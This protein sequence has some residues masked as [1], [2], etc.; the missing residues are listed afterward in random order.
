MDKQDITNITV[1]PVMAVVMIEMKTNHLL[2]VELTILDKNNEDDVNIS[3]SCR[4]EDS[5]A[6]SWLINKSAFLAQKRLEQYL[7]E[8][9]DDIE[10]SH[11]DVLRDYIEKHQKTES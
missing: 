4:W 1:N 11:L 7:P 5:N 6:K 10:K 2:P 3:L 8:A 9:W